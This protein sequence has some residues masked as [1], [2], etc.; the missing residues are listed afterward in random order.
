MKSA[1][2]APFGFM[3]EY[4]VDEH[5]NESSSERS[6]SAKSQEIHGT[7]DHQGAIIVDVDNFDDSPSELK[8]QKERPSAMSRRSKFS[9][10]RSRSMRSIKVG[11]HDELL[12]TT[13]AADPQRRST[14]LSNGQNSNSSQKGKSRPREPY[15]IDYIKRADKEYKVS[16]ISESELPIDYDGLQPKEVIF[17]ELTSGSYFGELS[18]KSNNKKRAHLRDVRM[19]RC[20]TSVWAV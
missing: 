6:K 16:E 10:Q 1:V 2:Q 13:K 5:S 20:F 9:S 15:Q 12:I 18:L 11:Y 8:N 19:G 4:K 7:F 14:A 3:T 17:A